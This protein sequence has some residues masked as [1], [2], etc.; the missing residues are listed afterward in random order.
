MKKKG[1]VRYQ[2]KNIMKDYEDLIKAT[3]NFIKK[4]QIDDFDRN[5]IEKIIE[6]E[7]KV[8]E[9]LDGIVRIRFNNIKPDEYMEYFYWIL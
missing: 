2:K 6:L 1:K 8:N 9:T 4:N 5:S 3:V 7:N